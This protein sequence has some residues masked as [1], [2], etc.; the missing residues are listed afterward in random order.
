[1]EG[2]EAGEC[3][4]SEPSHRSLA[5]YNAIRSLVEKQFLPALRRCDKEV[6]KLATGM[7]RKKEAVN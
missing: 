6:F 1:M 5:C 7:L 4:V 2:A 3:W